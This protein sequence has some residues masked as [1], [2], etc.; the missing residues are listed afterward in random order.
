MID[1]SVVI[2]TYNQGYVLDKVLAAYA[3]QSLPADQ[4]EVLLMDST[5]TDDT[6][7]IV[8]K[9]V[10]QFNLRHCVIAN[11][12]KAVA[13]NKGVEQATGRFIIISDADMICEPEFVAAHLDAQQQSADPVCYEGAAFDL[14]SLDWPPNP[15]TLRSQVGKVHRRDKRLGWYYFLTGNLSFPRKLFMDFGGFST[16]FK[17]YGWEDL[18]LGYRITTAGYALRYLPEA[19][20]YHYHVLSQDGVIERNIYKGQSARIFLAKHPELKWFLGLNPISVFLFNRIV[21]DG[22]VVSWMRRQ[23]GSSGV[24]AQFAVW[25]LKEYYYLS[26]ILDRGHTVLQKMS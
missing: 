17:G 1:I 2:G 13:R 23:V 3:A 24:L 5:S 22:R 21:P 11:E 26:G 20:N 15:A 25:F 9:Y 7:A 18:E 10:D 6:A 4:F 19:V 12:G 14:P 8:A 16:D